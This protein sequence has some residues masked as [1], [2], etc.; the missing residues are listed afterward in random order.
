MVDRYPKERL[1]QE[2]KNGFGNVE[3]EF[4]LGLDNMATMTGVGNWQLRV[5]MTDWDGRQYFALY[6]QFRVGPGQ[7][8]RLSLSGFNPV[9]T[10]GDSMTNEKNSGNGNMNGMAFTTKDNDNDLASH[11]NCAT[12]WGGGGWWYNHCYNA[13]LNGANFNTQK[14]GNT[15]GLVWFYGGSR[16]STSY[17]TWQQ[18]KMK[19]RK[20][21]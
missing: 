16:G 10:L 13:N 12:K 3:G 21:V 19:I 5:D 14:I 6:D 8:Y 9:S 20:T 7:K 4:W 1:W 17:N 2:Y 18:A 15:N 11:Y